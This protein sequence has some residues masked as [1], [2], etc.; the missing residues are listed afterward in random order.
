MS[1]YLNFKDFYTSVQKMA[2]TQP[3]YKYLLDKINRMTVFELVEFMNDIRDAQF[4]SFDDFV[5]CW[6][7][8]EYDF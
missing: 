4:E 6:E 3:L 5:L 1:D 2:E 7:Y 8:G